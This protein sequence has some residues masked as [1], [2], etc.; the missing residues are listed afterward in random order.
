MRKTHLTVNVTQW[1]WESGKGEDSGE[2]VTF[3]DQYDSSFE[4]KDL[5]SCIKEWD[6]IVRHLERVVVEQQ[7]E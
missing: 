5:E 2:T 6:K 1:V 3:Q 7:S 4:F